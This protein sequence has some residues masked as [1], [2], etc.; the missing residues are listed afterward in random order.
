MTEV[1]IVTGMAGAGK[2]NVLK[3]LED[4]GWETGDNIPLSLLG[5]VVIAPAG[6]GGG[7]ERPIAVGLG[8]GTRD[9]D[10]EAVI[11]HVDHLP[12]AVMQT[13]ISRT[14]QARV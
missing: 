11:R 7:P 14:A 9:F 8:T 10:P 5:R 3:T 4:L 2:T 13:I 1:L 12:I 6:D